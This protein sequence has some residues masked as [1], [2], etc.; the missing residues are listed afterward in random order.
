MAA[1]LEC[2]IAKIQNS[3][4]QEPSW[5]KAGLISTNGFWDSIVVFMLFLVTT[6]DG[7]PG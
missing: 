2:Q 1:I 3:F 7:H 4:T 6:P 5:H